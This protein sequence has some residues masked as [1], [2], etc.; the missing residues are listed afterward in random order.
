MVLKEDL[1]RI[2]LSQIVVDI[3]GDSVFL[4]CGLG[5][6]NC[7]ED[8]PCPVHEKFKFVKQDLAFMLENTTLEELS[9]GIKKGTTFLKY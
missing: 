3:D 2:T 4:R 9:I 5:L 7:S 8:H 1:K 6:S